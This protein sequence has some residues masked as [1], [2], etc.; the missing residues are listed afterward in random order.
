[1]QISLI[2]HFVYRILHSELAMSP[3]FEKLYHATPVLAK[4]HFLRMYQ[5]IRTCCPDAKETISYGMPT[6]RLRT[7]LCYFTT[8][9]NHLGFYPTGTGIEAFKE[10]IPP[11]K[12]SK[13]AIQFPYNQSLPEELI[14]EIVKYRANQ[15][16]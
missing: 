7:N 11:F 13:G 3:E 8:H 15:C 10:L 1:M 6:F 16:R 5:I 12:F 4:P 9:K 14:S 2:S